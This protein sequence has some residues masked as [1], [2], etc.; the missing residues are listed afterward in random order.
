MPSR[1][2]LPPS[3]QPPNWPSAT[4]AR[5]SSTWPA[6]PTR[7]C[8]AQRRPATSRQRPAR[9]T[10]RPSAPATCGLRPR[11]KWPRQ[12]LGRRRC[13]MGRRIVHGAWPP[14]GNPPEY[15]SSAALAGWAGVSLTKTTPEQSGR[16]VRPVCSP[17]CSRQRARP[18]MP[19]WALGSCLKRLAKFDAALASCISQWSTLVLKSTATPLLMAARLLDQLHQ[20]ERRRSSHL[21]ARVTQ[22]SNA[23]S[24]Y[25]DAARYGWP[26]LCAMPATS[27]TMPTLS[28]KRSMMVLATSRFWPDG[29][30]PSGRV[31]RS[32]AVQFD[33]AQQ[34]ARRTRGCQ[35]ARGNRCN[36]CFICKG[37]MAAAQQRAGSGQYGHERAIRAVSAFGSPRLAGL[38]LDCRS[39][40][41]PRQVTTR[42]GPSKLAALSVAH[43]RLQGGLAG[44]GPAAASCSMLAQQQA[45]VRGPGRS[46]RSSKS[47]SPTSPS[48]TRPII[49]SAAPL[50]R[51]Q[52]LTVRE[53]VT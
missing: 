7:S 21:C 20:A 40:V 27:G 49:C 13:K 17:K 10:T 52:T 32:A 18:P 24:P 44:D 39:L 42:Q 19:L 31:P 41:S 25:F 45:M 26:G 4:R 50:P 12:P 28:S 38:L 22:W 15:Q 33:Q 14:D 34:A 43:R 35:A 46:P 36:T 9:P 47:I 1:R 2:P 11:A 3:E 48:N 29:H 30:I 16:H 37:E 53:S 23:G 8:R 51:R 5:R 6:R